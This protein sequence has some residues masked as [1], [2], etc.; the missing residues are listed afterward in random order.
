[1]ALEFLNK[2]NDIDDLRKL[3]E[4]D[5]FGLAKDLREFIIDIVSKKSSTIK[6]YLLKFLSSLSFL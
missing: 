6:S 2:V 3:S 5:L 1:M 4:E